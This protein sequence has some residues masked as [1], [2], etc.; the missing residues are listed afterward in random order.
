MRE[1]TFTQAKLDAL[2]EEMDRDP[3]VII[4]G[5]DVGNYGGILGGL[6]GLIDIYGPERVRE[7]PLTEAAII[8]VSVGA[9]LTGIRPVAEV[10]FCD[11]LGTCMDDIINQAAKIKYLFGEKVKL[12]LTI[13]TLIGA[14]LSA[15][16]HHSQSLEGL[17]MSIPGLKIV[18]PSTPYDAKGLLKS[19]IRDD[20]PVL[21][22]EHKIL[23]LQ[24]PKG[25][26]PKKE[27]LIPLGKADI[28]R[29]G[30]DVTVVATAL[31]V[32]RA[33]AAAERLQERGI[34]LEVIDP[35]TL[36]PLDKE[37]IIRSVK[38]T[39]RLIIMTEECKTGSSAAEI[40]AVVADE[41]FDYLDAPIKRL[42]AP[43]IPVPYSEVLEKA[44]MPDQEDLIR[45]VIEITSVEN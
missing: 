45:A 44:F 41:G 22:F 32:L 34:S 6:K 43:D 24:G 27:Y 2:K 18:V 31:M 25:N 13:R 7:T 1:L 28:K 19:A 37:T 8:G 11:F 17:F 33:L 35:R 9:A 39:G 4:M 5:E 15:G 21:Y 10:M 40:S 30:T 26:V 29:E 20:G 12:P 36:A 14:G 42:N 16:A 38:K 3:S 23:V